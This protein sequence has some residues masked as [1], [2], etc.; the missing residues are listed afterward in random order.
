MPFVFEFADPEVYARALASTGP[1]FEAI[2]AV[3][4][5]A[6]LDSAVELGGT[7]PG[8]SSSSGA[9]SCS[10][11]T[12]P[13]K[14]AADGWRHQPRLTSDRVEQPAFSL[15]RDH[16]RGAAAV[17][18]RPAGRRL[19]LQRV[20]TVGVPP[21]RVGRPVRS[22]GGG[23]PR[24]FTHLGAASV[25][26]TATASTLGDSYC[27]LAWGKKLAGAAGPDVAAAVIRGGSTASE[28]GQALARWARLVATDPNAV[29]ADDVEALREA[30][31]DDQQIFALTTYVALRLAFSTVNDALGARPDASSGRRRRSRSVPPSASV[32]PW[33]P[34]A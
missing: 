17:R 1:A 34:E 19:R 10:S 26:V 3:G 29:D 25:L 8:G 20:A 5:E 16:A 22:H 13:A 32:A 14:A 6:F 9:R 2:Q 33:T 21:G 28:P 24:R 31:F 11:A 12:S 30:G 15:R 7:G 27:T 18:Q 4:E 23:D